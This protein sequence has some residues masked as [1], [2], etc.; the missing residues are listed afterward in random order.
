VPYFTFQQHRIHYREQGHGELLFVLPGN[1]ASSA[2]HA[3]ELEHFG[4]R[5]QAVALDYLGT[6]QSDR[7]DDWPASWWQD[8][9]HQVVALADHLGAERFHAVGTSG[10][11]I[12]ALWLAILYPQRLV[13][14]VADSTLSIFPPE[15]VQRNVVIDRAR[16][17]EGQVGFWAFAHGED[18]E[19]VIEADTALICALAERGGDWL[20]GRLAEV[21]CPMLITASSQDDALL[22][23]AEDNLAMAQQ[24]SQARLYLHHTGGH[25]LMWSQPDLFRAQADLF[26]SQL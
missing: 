2:C 17:T 3:G 8:G 11:A 22:G 23:G 15:L 10:G 4:Q 14:V 6:G 26:L 25:P 9:A 18:W 24:I 12:V 5:Y 7:L 20:E 21:T 16:R 13:S 1:T 19:Q